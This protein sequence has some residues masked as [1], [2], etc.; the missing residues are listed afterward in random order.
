AFGPLA[1]LAFKEIRG[2]LGLDAGAYDFDVYVDG[3]TIN[4]IIDVDGL[5]VVGG[6]DYSVYAVG[7][8]SPVIDIEPLVVEDMRRAVATSATL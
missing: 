5:M 2:Y 3:T 8:V 1:D 6:M 4:P 7:V